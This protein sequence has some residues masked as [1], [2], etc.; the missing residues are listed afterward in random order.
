MGNP[1]YRQ[2]LNRY[3]DQTYCQFRLEQSNV[4][5]LKGLYCFTVNTTLKYIGKSSDTFK[6]RIN[7]G[8][9]CIHPKN[10]YRDGQATN[11]H[12]NA[13]IAPC[14]QEL[15]L[16][17]HPMADDVEIGEIETAL[18][19]SYQPEWNTQLKRFC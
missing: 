15:G 3:G 2:F 4:A 19:A 10:C 14:A 5:D 7:Q 12:L 17:V 8:Y 13:L 11:C 9:G 16:F 18:I 6:R 1:L